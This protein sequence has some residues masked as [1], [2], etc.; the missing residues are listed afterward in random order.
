MDRV[1]IG[2][3]VSKD[4]LDAAALPS[5]QKRRFTNDPD[6]IAE[7]VAWARELAPERIVFESTGHYQ[8]LA[9]GALLAGSG[10][11]IDESWRWKQMLGGALRQSGVLAAACLYGL[12]H[13][14][15]RLAEDHEHARLLAEALAPLPAVELDP[16]TVETN[17]VIFGVD[18][19][20]ALVARLAE[21][22]E[23]QAVDAH[24][25]RAV[26]HLDV[27]REDVLRAF[28]AVAEALA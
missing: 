16:S 6:S 4:H 5:L 1:F 19:A 26:T 23:L 28:D 25:V 3:D 18:D 13:H 9:V 2:V 15:D 22:V 20:P 12:D 10:E 7:L 17:I 8:K 14:V 27:S 21:R 24:R 11:T